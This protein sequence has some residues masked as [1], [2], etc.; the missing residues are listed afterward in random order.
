VSLPTRSLVC[1]SVAQ[2]RFDV[3]VALQYAATPKMTFRSLK[4]ALVI[5]GALVSAL[6]VAQDQQPPSRRSQPILFYEPRYDAAASN[7]NEIATQESPF[8]HPGK[9]FKKPSDIFN[10]GEGS[11][12]FIMPPLLQLPRPNVSSK[13]LKELLDKRNDRA[14]QTPEELARLLTAEE[15]FK[16]PDFAR[17][18]QEKEKKTWME[19][20]YERWEQEQFGTTNQFKGDELFGF[21]RVL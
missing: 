9:E 21:A 11:A 17:D 16:I 19:R 18:G 10:T 2:L 4:Y 1:F 15:I 7:L 14:L 6:G 12:N 5:A 13:R 3:P 8:R 20:G